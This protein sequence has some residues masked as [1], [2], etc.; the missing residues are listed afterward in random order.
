MVN[1]RDQSRTKEASQSLKFK[2][3]RNGWV[4]YI[5]QLLDRL[6]PPN[7]PDIDAAHTDLS[8]AVTPP[9]IE[10]MRMSVRQTKSAKA[11]EPDNIPAE[12]LKPNIEV[13]ANMVHVLSSKIC[14]EEQVPT[15]WK[16]GYLTKIPN[17]RDLS[18]CENYR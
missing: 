1:Q 16:E 18:K 2:K 15:D 4:E 6:I 11:A 5:E 7:L 3:Q 8:K 13:T 10:E 14:E 9:T 12:A 17:K